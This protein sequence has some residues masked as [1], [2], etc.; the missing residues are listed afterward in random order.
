MRKC[1]V[2][3]IKGAGERRL[4]RAFTLVELLV[5]IAIIAILAGLLLPTL[6]KAKGKAQRTACLNNL[7]QLMVGWTLYTDENSGMLMQSESQFPVL[8]TNEPIWVF[9]SMANASEATDTNLLRQGALFP[10]VK[11]PSLYR[12]PTDR[13]EVNGVGRVRSYSM[14][15]WMNGVEFKSGTQANYRRYVRFSQITTPALSGAAVLIEDHEDQI[16]DPKFFILAGSAPMG[17]FYDMPANRRH[18]Y[19]YVLSFADGHAEAWRLKDSA[20]RNWKKPQTIPSNQNE[21]YLK[22]IEACTALK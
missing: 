7:K 11:N 4:E 16:D 5:V 14:N 9:G 22:L 10:Y 17:R 6:A 15:Y 3:R 20:M 21:D 12:C 2:Q 18:D 19:S 8:G 13:S 1:L